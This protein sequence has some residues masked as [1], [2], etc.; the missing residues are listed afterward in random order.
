[1]QTQAMVLDAEGGT[2]TL[3]DLE[4]DGASHREVLVELV[5]CGVCHSDDH[6]RTGDVPAPTPLICGHEGAGIVREVGAGVTYVKEGDHVAMSF[7]PACGRCR[8]CARGQMFLCDRGSMILA[9]TQLDGTHRFHRADGE[10]VGQLCMLG[11]FARHTVVPEDSVVVVPSDLPL[12]AMSLLSCGVTTGWGA[13][14]RRGE[15]KP[16]DVAVVW[17]IGGVGTAA[18]QGASHAGASRIF[19]VDPVARKLEWATE[20]GATDAIQND[21]QS[22]ADLAGPVMDATN[23]QG[24]DVVIMTPGVNDADQLSAAYGMVAKGGTLVLVGVTPATFT[25]LQVPVLD[26][27]MANK[28]IK[29]SLY[30]SANPQH[31][32]GNLISM[33][34]AGQLR[35]DEMI[36]R[37]YPLADLN[38]AFAD[39]FA[40]EVIRG[41]LTFDT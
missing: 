2:F 7:I 34:R 3:E 41:V 6:S 26:L 28:A 9:G 14:V 27:I 31:E 17:G 39:M 18:V 33:Y 32:I 23:G 29:G 16:G 8:W 20:F 19:A 12:E 24:A 38:T 22:A 25:D 37:R 13:A 4:L 11:A 40:G 1:M 10:A 21:G 5:A 15:V 30:G 36:T 35:L